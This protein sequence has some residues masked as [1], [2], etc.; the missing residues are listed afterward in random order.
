MGP[1]GWCLSCLLLWGVAFPAYIVTRRRYKRAP[2]AT[3]PAGGI[4]QDA[5]LISQLAALVDFHSQGIV[6]DEE[7]Q[8]KKKV[9]VQEMLK[10]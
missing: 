9:I 10:Q 7:F 4:P 3:P 6:T 5:D 2:S 8:A 1:I